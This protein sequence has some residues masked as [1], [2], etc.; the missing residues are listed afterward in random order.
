MSFSTSSWQQKGEEG[1]PRLANSTGKDLQWN[2]SLTLLS[3][4]THCWN[5][6]V[7][8]KNA[9]FWSGIPKGMKVN[10][11]LL[12]VHGLPFQN[13][14]RWQ[15]YYVWTLSLSL[16]SCGRYP[17]GLWSW[18]L[19][20]GGKVTIYSSW[21]LNLLTRTHQDVKTK[22]RN[23]SP[24]SDYGCCELRWSL[25]CGGNGRRRQFYR[26]LLQYS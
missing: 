9:S 6:P 26:K 15:M 22:S 7:Y 21:V 14:P 18:A 3:S 2:L 16:C 13:P 23:E 11:H 19:G 20:S 5:V 24:S 8:M 10:Y 4:L 12:L 25:L 17:T 1:H